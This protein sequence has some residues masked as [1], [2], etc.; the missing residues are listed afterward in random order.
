MF[1]CFCFTRFVWLFSKKREK[2]RGKFWIFLFY[3]VTLFH[4]SSFARHFLE[5]NKQISSKILLI[6]VNVSSSKTLIQKQNMGNWSE[7]K[8]FKTDFIYLGIHGTPGHKY[9]NSWSQCA[10]LLSFSYSVRGSIKVPCIC[11]SLFLGSW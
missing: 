8:C 6:N 2:K 11:V 10:M 4:V 9:A 7:W 3:F 5:A 1:Y